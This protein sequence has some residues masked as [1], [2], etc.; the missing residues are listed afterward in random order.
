MS[1][2]LYIY[3]Y[4]ERERCIYVLYIYIYIYIH[5][6]LACGLS[7]GVCFRDSVPSASAG[8]GNLVSIRP[9]SVR[10]EILDFAGFD[11]SRILVLRGGIPRHTG[12]F[13]E[14][15]SQQI[16]AGIISVGRLLARRRIPLAAQTRPSTADWR[17]RAA[18]RRR[19]T[20]TCTRPPGPHNTSRTSKV[21]SL[22]LLRYLVNKC[23]YVY[24]CI[25]ICVLCM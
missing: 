15:V 21:G 23:I 13:P 8:L 25:C 14:S 3:I 12:N 22:F 18:R 10:T 9:I 2:S 4:I 24:M 16:L 20:R 11:S 6:S 19:P 5:M 1:L 7:I 17:W